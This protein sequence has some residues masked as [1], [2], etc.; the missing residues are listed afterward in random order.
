M[1]TPRGMLSIRGS[2]TAL[3]RAIIKAIDENPRHDGESKRAW[4]RRIAPIAG[5]NAQTVPNIANILEAERIGQERRERETEERLSQDLACLA[6]TGLVIR[7]FKGFAHAFG[8]MGLM[9]QTYQNLAREMHRTTSERFMDD[10]VKVC[11]RAQKLVL[12]D[13]EPMQAV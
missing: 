8:M 9:A 12:R 1:N 6:D 11:E 5:C 13:E 7:R 3:Q 10:L 2:G 4:Y